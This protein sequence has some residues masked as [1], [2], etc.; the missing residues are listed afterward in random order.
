MAQIGNPIIYHLGRQGMI[1]HQN[2]WLSSNEELLVA[3]NACFEND[4]VQKEPAA[5]EYDSIGVAVEGP[6][7]TLSTA[8]DLVLQAIWL[9]ASQSTALVT[10]V[11]TG[12]ASQTSPWTFTVTGTATAGN[13]AILAVGQT[14]ASTDNPV[15]TSVT[16]SKGNTRTRLITR[17][18]SGSINADID[19]WGAILTATLTTAVDTLT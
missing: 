10:T 16:D 11:F 19:L 4:Y 17:P 5:P 13:C 18:G 3:E 9:Q 8:S 1:A 6:A 15:A 12:V 7:G 2:S 14:N